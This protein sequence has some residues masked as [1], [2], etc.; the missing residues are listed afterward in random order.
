[1]TAKTNIYFERTLSFLR[2]LK[3][4]VKVSSKLGIVKD[5]NEF[6][7]MFSDYLKLHSHLDVGVLERLNEI[8]E[9]E[10]Q[11]MVFRNSYDEICDIFNKEIANC[12]TRDKILANPIEPILDSRFVISPQ[13]ET[14][15]SNWKWIVSERYNQSLNFDEILKCK[16]GDYYFLLQQTGTYDALLESNI[17]E[18]PLTDFQYFLLVQFEKPCKI[19]TAMEVFQQEFDIDSDTEKIQLQNVT[20]KLIKELIF[21]MFIVEDLSN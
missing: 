20:E 13:V 3:F 9:I 4:Y 1:M 6:Y 7:I 5:S 10:N 15:E 8:L 14:Y 11:K 17:F 18:F 16:K 21:R 12:K 19:S 2:Y